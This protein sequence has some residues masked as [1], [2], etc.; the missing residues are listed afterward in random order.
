MGVCGSV[1]I[2]AASRP[3]RKSSKNRN[4]PGS[5]RSSSIN[6]NCVGTNRTRA[7]KAIRGWKKSQDAAAQ[8]NN[9]QATIPTRGCTVVMTTSDPASSPATRKRVASRYVAPP[10]RRTDVPGCFSRKV[11]PCPPAIARRE[12]STES[13]DLSP[14][15]AQSQRPDFGRPVVTDLNSE[16]RSWTIR[17]ESPDPGGHPGTDIVAFD[18]TCGLRARHDLFLPHHIFEEGETAR[19]PFPRDKPCAESAASTDRNRSSRISCDP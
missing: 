6:Q 18:R 19:S 15:A 13:G 11:P 10:P 14:R 5:T 16:G 7:R 1:S 17:P 3:R 8:P 4:G 2:S 9:A 12:G